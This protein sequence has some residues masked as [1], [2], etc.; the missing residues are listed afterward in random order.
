MEIRKEIRTLIMNGNIEDALLKIPKYHPTLLNNSPIYFLLQCQLFIE[1][2]SKNNTEKA[3]QCAQQV[4]SKYRSD[5]TIPIEFQSL[6]QVFYFCY[7][8]HLIIFRNQWDY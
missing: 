4:L 3:L 5:S 6:L 1:F 2:I 8:S 7:C